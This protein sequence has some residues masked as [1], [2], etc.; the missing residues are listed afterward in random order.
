MLPIPFVDLPPWAPGALPLALAPSDGA[1]NT[2]TENAALTLD[3]SGLALG[4]IIA[5]A[6]Q[7][8]GTKQADIRIFYDPS[9]QK[10]PA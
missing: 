3:T 7:L 6:Q 1:F 5:S 8:L 10:P 4:R 2:P 9:H